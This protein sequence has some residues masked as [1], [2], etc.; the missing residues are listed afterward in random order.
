MTVRF[1]TPTLHGV[2]DYAAASALILLP[3]ALSMQQHSVFVHWFSVIAGIGLIAY[4]LMTDYKLS[5]K[6]L[7]SYRAHLLLD[8]VA[9]AAFIVV[10]FTHNGDEFSRIYSLVMGV[11]VIAVI[12]LSGTPRTAIEPEVVRS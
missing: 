7:F 9:S 6:G 2:L 11:G 1:I 10:A 12:M 4:S 3:F 8:S 5:W